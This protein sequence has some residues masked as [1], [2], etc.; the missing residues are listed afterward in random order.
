MYAK[1]YNVAM[2][3]DLSHG[4][5]GVNNQ[6]NIS[7]TAVGEYISISEFI[8]AIEKDSTLGFRIEEFAMVPYSEE[9]LQATFIIKNISIDP[10][11][12]SSSASVSSGTVTSAPD[13]NNNSNNNGQS[14]SNSNAN[15]NN[16]QS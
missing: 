15:S 13:Q 14:G 10:S 11:S 3:A 12:L 2:K 1:K 8:Y 6:Y 9:Y 16:Q 5:S 4:S 7:F